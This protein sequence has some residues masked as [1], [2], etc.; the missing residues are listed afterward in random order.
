MTATRLKLLEKFLIYRTT[1][2]TNR[3]SD[4]RLKTNTKQ[5]RKKKQN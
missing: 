5:S 1:K 4:K 2:K 3:T